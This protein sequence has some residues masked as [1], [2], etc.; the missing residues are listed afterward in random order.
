M[1]SPEKADFQN[2]RDARVSWDA[3]EKEVKKKSFPKLERFR[4]SR[5]ARRIILYNII[6]LGFLLGAVIVF[7]QERTRTITERQDKLELAAAFAAAW[8]STVSNPMFNMGYEIRA[9]REDEEIVFERTDIVEYDQRGL[10]TR[11]QGE[12][13]LTAP[14]SQ[15]EQMERFDQLL[16][17]VAELEGT[18]PQ[19]FFVD[20]RT[21]QATVLVHRIVTNTSD[22]RMT[23]VVSTPLGAI[24]AELTAQRSAILQA[25]LSAVAVAIGLSIILA[26]SIATPIHELADAAETVRDSG[27]NPTTAKQIKI[28][29]LDGRPDEIGRLS[30]AMRDMTKT[31]YEQIDHNQRFAADV[32]HEIKNPLA[33]ISSAVQ[34]L[35]RIDDPVRRRDLEKV[36]IDD[37]NRMDRL[38]TDIS[39][40]S[41]LD[42]DLVRAERLSFNLGELLERI[43]GF[44]APEA[45]DKNI[46]LVLKKSDPEL[47]YVGLEQRLTQVFSNLISNAVSICDSGDVVTVW[48]FVTR[49]HVF[50]IVEDTGPGIPEENLKTIF[51]RF[52][53]S[54]PNSFG[55]NSGLGLAISK[56]IIEGHQGQLWA[57]NIY[58]E[59]DHNGPR[60]GARFVVSLPRV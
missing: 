19:T 39:Q 56:Q 26:Y 42:A 25:F 32:T 47:Y 27:A 46:D 35:A 54:R 48:N 12:S 13:E 11:F 23:V 7:T 15:E 44:Y 24:D 2:Q 22:G 36:L 6:S 33:S 31:L 38:I 45:F 58:Q 1:A 40:A 9:F 18:Y 10:L 29:N 52:Y 53:S 49:D 4:G 5:I 37:V 51:N 28:P 14:L 21:S 60:L 41:K 17:S 57:E 30:L 3:T 55:K 50:I 16:R 59:D 43:I 34:S 8:V 20:L